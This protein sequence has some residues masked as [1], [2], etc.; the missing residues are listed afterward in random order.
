MKLHTLFEH[1]EREQLADKYLLIRVHFRLYG[2]E[3]ARIFFITDV[4][5]SVNTINN[6][7]FDKLIEIT[8]D[9]FPYIKEKHR[10]K[11]FSVTA[12][13]EQFIP[14][15]LNTMKDLHLP[16]R[17]QAWHETFSEINEEMK[18]IMDEDN[19]NDFED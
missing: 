11:Q 7:H 10:R 19:I 14:G 1:S 9:T 16:Y 17:V 2:V 6:S 4:P 8:C 12:Y 15:F 5:K 13:P 18:I 3:M